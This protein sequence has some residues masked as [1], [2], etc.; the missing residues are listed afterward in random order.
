[1]VS[2]LGELGVKLLTIAGFI[3]IFILGC[4]AISAVLG[5]S[6]VFSV[7]WFFVELKMFKKLYDIKG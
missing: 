6:P 1:M 7:I 5:E 2:K 4:G 3:G